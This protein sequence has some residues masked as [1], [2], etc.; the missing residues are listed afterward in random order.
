MDLLEADA[1]RAFAVF[2]EHRNF[3]SAAAALHISQPSLHVKIKKLAAG[4][5]VTL[6]E[7]DGR[8]LVLTAA[9]ARLAAFAADTA[10]A[11]DD[12]LT[13]LHQDTARLT[14]AAG[15]GTLRWV[16]SDAIRGIS[17]TGRSLHLITANR[18]GALDAA[19]TGRAD[20]AVLAQ[21]PPPRN[22]RAARIAGCPQTLVIDEAHP[23]AG[24]AQVHLTDLD[25][26][27]LVVPPPG[28][29]HRRALERALAD[30]AVTWHPVAEVDGWDLLIHFAG[31]GIGAT[32][33]NGCIP[34]P[35]GLTAIPV[36]DLPPIGYWATWR[37]QRHDL[38]ASIL[39]Y[40]EAG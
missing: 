15:R 36:A 12:L 10:R 2:A 11:A 37:P 27:D 5:D 32:I 8:A 22:L 25:G 19:M 7:R 23:L 13:E 33:V 16:I 20:V 9:G 14:I 18:D 35:S 29:M 31:L 38:I 1:L 4:L 30:A 21:D 24:R 26:F 40:F 17:A 39:P 3:T 34:P 28:R 6:Y